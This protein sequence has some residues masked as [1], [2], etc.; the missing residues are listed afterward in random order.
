MICVD[1]FSTFMKENTTQLTDI[2]KSFNCTARDTKLYLHLLS[3]GPRTIQRLANELRENRVTIHSA[4]EKMIDLGFLFESRKGKHRIVAASD[5]KIFH[6]L[7]EKR[8]TEL[9]NID[10]TVSQMTTWLESKRR[11]DESVPSVKFYEGIDGLKRML[12]ETLEAKNEV[13][14]FTFVD[15][16]SKLLT[17]KYLE[18]YYKRRAEKDI[19]SRLIF[20]V[21]EF[22]KQVA[23]YA[24]SLKMVVRF[25][26]TE[27]NWKSGFFA[28]N[29][30]LAIQSFTEGKVTC[31][32]IENEDIA[33]FYR[34]VIFELCWKQASEI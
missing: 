23:T 11:I 18:N 5:P 25:L 31:T 30:M 4:V 22:G 19:S 27:I 6:R 32:I 7:I 20:P 16:F 17:P 21:G 34:H 8:Q 33:Y 2:M 24:E 10:E 29:N 13:L 3:T 1:L 12:E 14:V 9:N 28:W 15:L 26:P